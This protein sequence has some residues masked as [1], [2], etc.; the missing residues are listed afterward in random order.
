MISI[1]PV[2]VLLHL[3]FAYYHVYCLLSALPMFWLSAYL[4]VCA[5]DLVLANVYLA[6]I[7]SMLIGGVSCHD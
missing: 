1:H 6:W 3:I 4:H 2:L 5:L 7:Y